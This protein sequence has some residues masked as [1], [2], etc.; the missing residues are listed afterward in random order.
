M[1]SFLCVFAFGWTVVADGDFALSCCSTLLV[2]LKW[3]SRFCRLF[4]FFFDFAFFRWC[5]WQTRENWLILV[6]LTKKKRVKG[7]LSCSKARVLP[8]HH[9]PH[10]LWPP[11]GFCYVR[12]P[13]HF[14]PSIKAESSK[15]AAGSHQRMRGEK[16]GAEGGFLELGQFLPGGFWGKQGKRCIAMFDV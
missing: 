14:P 1:Q 16:K 12:V 2:L 9:L 11:F 5:F 8:S 7:V 3:F 15:T 13:F 10:S 6:H 4:D